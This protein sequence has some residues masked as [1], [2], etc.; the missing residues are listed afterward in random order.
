VRVCFK[1]GGKVS[2]V[3]AGRSVISRGPNGQDGASKKGQV[4]GVG[5]TGVPTLGNPSGLLLKR[6]G[7]DS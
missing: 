5:G 4:R 2:V 1:E 6:G 7:S 3:A